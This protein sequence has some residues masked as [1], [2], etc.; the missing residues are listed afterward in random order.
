LRRIG[1]PG[2]K[3]RTSDF[4]L[5]VFGKVSLALFDPN[6]RCT[7]PQQSNNFEVRRH[8]QKVFLGF[9]ET[10]IGIENI[11]RGKIQPALIKTSTV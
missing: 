1:S 4:P 7:H 2:T 11:P 5:D 6:F 3:A 10:P 8:P 9:T